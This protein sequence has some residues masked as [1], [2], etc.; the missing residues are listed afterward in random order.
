MKNLETTTILAIFQPWREK[1]EERGGGVQ[2]LLP[3]ATDRLFW[4]CSVKS[5]L[6]APT[7][8]NP[9]CRA[10]CNRSPYRYARITRTHHHS[11]HTSPIPHAPP[12]PPPPIPPSLEISLPWAPPI[13]RKS[14]FRAQI[15]P[16][17]LRPRGPSKVSI[18][19]TTPVKSN[20]PPYRGTT[21]KRE[22]RRDSGPCGLAHHPYYLH[23]PPPP[24]PLPRPA[25]PRL[26]FATPLF[27]V[28]NQQHPKTPA[29][30][31]RKSYPCALRP[32][33]TPPDP[34]PPPQPAS[35][36]YRPVS[37]ERA[38][39]GSHGVLRAPFPRGG[40]VLRAIVLENLSRKSRAERQHIKTS[41]KK[42]DKTSAAVMT[43]SESIIF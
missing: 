28:T 3:G 17:N 6:F 16:S 14:V 2:K 22:G 36:L 1:E 32:V 5:T 10:V 9:A 13:P 12:P 41:N 33:Y 29:S 40:I 26:S 11:S 31:H 43:V 20:F 35:S 19:P 23:P 37:V 27:P 24:F 15:P 8:K 30:Y 25:S 38:R 34:F 39:A 42:R 7:P 21:Q 4:T 18:I